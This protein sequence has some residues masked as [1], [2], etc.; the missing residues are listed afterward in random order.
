[1]TTTILCVT[2]IYPLDDYYYTIVYPVKLLLRVTT[3][4]YRW[5][6]YAWLVY[7]VDDYYYGWLVYPVDYYYYTMCNYSLPCRCI[8]LYYV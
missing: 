2:I 8:L 5:H 3:I 7:P 6:Y 4:F 1:M